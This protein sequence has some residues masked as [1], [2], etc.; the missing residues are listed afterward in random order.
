MQSE[1]TRLP[2]PVGLPVY[3][4]EEEDTGEARASNPQ[5]RTACVPRCVHPFLTKTRAHRC[6]PPDTAGNDLVK[7]CFSFEISS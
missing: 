7:I 5:E 4:Y 6:L 2:L 1:A 3:L